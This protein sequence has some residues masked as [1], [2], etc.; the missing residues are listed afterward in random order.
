MQANQ[1]VSHVSVI[2]T[3]MPINHTVWNFGLMSYLE[4]SENVDERVPLHEKDL[5]VYVCLQ[6]LLATHAISCGG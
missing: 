4:G 5:T 6:Q 2:F 1:G 3:Y